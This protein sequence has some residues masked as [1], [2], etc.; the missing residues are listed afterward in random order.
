MVANKQLARQELIDSGE[1]A[2]EIRKLLLSSE[3]KRSVNY[4]GFETEVTLNASLN[5]YCNGVD[6][7]NT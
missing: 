2:R 3:R 7:I 4:I 1:A 6:L 5:R